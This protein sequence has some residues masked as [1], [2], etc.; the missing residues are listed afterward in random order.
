MLIN[1]SKLELYTIFAE[2]K[3]PAFS[4][5]LNTLLKIVINLILEFNLR[6]NK[7]LIRNIDMSKIFREV[8]IDNQI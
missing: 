2:G 6:E 7:K 8:G 5:L 3:A 1:L 4:I